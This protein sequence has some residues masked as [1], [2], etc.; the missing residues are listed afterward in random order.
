ME[1]DGRPQRKSTSPWTYVVIGCGAAVLLGLIGISGFT[2]LMYRQGKEMADGFKDPKVR[3]QKTR[4]VLPFKTL[5]PGYYTAGAFSVPMLMDFAI[6]TDRPPENRPDAQGFD[7]R[8]FIFMNMR[9][10]RDN[11]E[12]ME[13]YLRGEAPAPEDS[14][15][16]QSSVNFDAKELIGRGT[17]NMNG[18]P[19]LYAAHRGEVNKKG[20]K[21]SGIVT[22]I[23]PECPD[24]RL[25]FG[26]W[27]GPDPQA[28]KPVAEAS[29][30]GTSADPAAMHDFLSHF[31]LCGGKK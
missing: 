2:Y 8:S 15:W 23:L 16:R 29:Y 9:H 28:G 11:R 14:A 20:D 12:K 7:Q 31:E 1:A 10:M 26:V 24:D 4:E 13:R 5:P 22:M 17:L 30:A 21:E 18:M 19:V 25:R 6:L 27:I 3:D